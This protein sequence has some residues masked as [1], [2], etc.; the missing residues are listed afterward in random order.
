MKNQLPK[1]KQFKPKQ[2]QEIDWKTKAEKISYNRDHRIA[3]TNPQKMQKCERKNL[4]WKNLIQ[5]TLRKKKSQVDKIE[6]T[7]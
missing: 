7:Y 4:T 3:P 6:I 5:N 2:F 1:E